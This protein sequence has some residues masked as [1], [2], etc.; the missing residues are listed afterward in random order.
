MITRPR[1]LR[2]LR[3][4]GMGMG[5]LDRWRRLAPLMSRIVPPSFGR[6]LYCGDYNAGD[7]QF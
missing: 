5:N 4:E 6:A 7:Q 3:V 1:L 2:C